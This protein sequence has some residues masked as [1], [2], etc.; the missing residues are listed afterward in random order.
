MLHCQYPTA[1]ILHVSTL[2]LTHYIS[3]LLLIC[4]TVS[5]LLLTHYISTLLLICYSVS[6]LLLA[7]YMSVH[8][9]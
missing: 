3:T 9:C 1:S 4:Y 7:Y 5:T 8:Y 2:L 6:T